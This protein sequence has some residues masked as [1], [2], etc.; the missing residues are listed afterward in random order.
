MS[1]ALNSAWNLA[2][3]LGLTLVSA[4]ASFFA[5]P[6]LLRWLGAERLGAFKALTDW[7]GQLTFVEFGLD[8]ALM[9]AFVVRISRGDRAGVM[10]MAA[11]GIHA[12]WWVAFFQIAGGI[13]LVVALPHLISLDHLTTSEL[14]AAGA[15]ALAPIAMTPLLVFRALAESR[16]R[17]FMNSVLLTAQVLV[18]TALAL[19]AARLGWGLIGQAVAFAVA[20]SLTLL[21]LALLGTRAYRGVWD[22][23][24]EDMDRHTLRRLSWP[25]FVHGLTDRVGLVSDNLIVA[26]ILG[27]AAVVPFFLT[28]QLAGLTQSQVRSVGQATWAGFAELYAQGNSVRLRTRLLELT[29][30][31]SGLGVAALAPVAAYNR[32]FVHLWVGQDGYAGEAVTTL[33]CVNAVLWGVFA[34]WGWAVL[35]T[36]HIGW[37]VPFGILS[38][39]VNV[40]VSV[41]A[42]ITFGLVGPLLGTTAGLGL[43]TSWALPRVLHRAL[44]I[45]P[46]A[47]WRAVLSPLRWGLAFAVVLQAVARYYPPVHWLELIAMAGPSV[48]VGLVLWWRLSLGGEDRSAWWAMV[49]SVAQSR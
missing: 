23:S 31:V 43:V 2:A 8:G 38:T 9:A 18:M 47:L 15:V 36:G 29:G 44:A 48:A 1:R 3:G 37:W 24:P 34:L 30:M 6:W 40:V 32:A 19:I 26:W 27:P 12:Y 25:T 17:G 39:V 35:G 21:T 7:V 16:Q 5:T 49:R 20:Q 28:Q 22:A 10:R 14:R 4:V 42:T 11:A 46:R 45:P 33:A 41:L 13:L